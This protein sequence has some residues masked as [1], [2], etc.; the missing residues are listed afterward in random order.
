MTSPTLAERPIPESSTQPLPKAPLRPEPTLRR[1]GIPLA[2]LLVTLCSTTAVGMRYMYN[3]HLHD[4][5]YSGEA[6]ILPYSWVL[7]NLRDWTSGLPFSL[8]LVGILLAHEFGHYIACR[9]YG[10]RATLPYL[11]PAPSLSGTF[12]A[13]IRLRTGIRS[14]AALIV[15]GAA[16]PIAGFL[17]AIVTISIGIAFSTYASEGIMQVQPTLT[18]FLMQSLLHPQTPLSLIVPHPILTASWIG[19]LITAL[20]LIPAGQLDGGHIVYAISPAA[21]RICSRIVVAALF[22]LGIFCWGGWLIWAIVLLLPA[23]RHPRIPD[24]QPLTRAQFTLL[25]ICAVIFI[26][27]LSY[28]PFPGYSL[29]HGL[30]RL[31]NHLH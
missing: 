19:I 23:M 13:V 18:I 25:P 4:A 1:F 10:V 30:S 12:G 27:C 26:L 11:L 7:A 24:S 5:P 9:F 20:N 2:L 15:I 3:F 14:R 28:Q 31:F 16:G 29:F 8:T 22:V 17:L 6:D 21:H